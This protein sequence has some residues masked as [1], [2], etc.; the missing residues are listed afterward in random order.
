MKLERWLWMAPVWRANLEATLLAV[1]LIGSLVAMVPY[2]QIVPLF[3]GLVLVG[4][5]IPSLIGLRRRPLARPWAAA[6]LLELLQAG[7]ITLG[8]LLIEMAWLALL[9]PDLPS[10]Q[11]GQITEILVFTVSAGVYLFWRVF[12]PIW[13][14]WT[15]MRQTRFAWALTHAFLVLVS[16]AVLAAVILL[17]LLVEVNDSEVIKAGAPTL[18]ALLARLTQFIY[19]VLL[20]SPFAIA[21]TLIVVLPP[22]AAVS[23]WVSR[24]LARRLERLEAAAARLSQGDWS[25]R[26]APEGQDEIGRLQAS[27]NR[28]ASELEKTN[29]DLVAQRD[30]VAGLLRVQRELTASVSHEL[31]TPVATALAYLENDLD[32]LEALPAETLRQDLEIARHEIT[33]LQTLI[34]DLFTLSKAEVNQLSLELTAVDLLP[35]IVQS[36][37]T[38]A[39]LAWQSRRVQVQAE[40]PPQLPFVQADA[41]RVEQVLRNLLANGIRHTPPGGFVIVS[42][43]ALPAGVRVTVTDSGEGISAD[44]LPHIWERFYRGPGQPGDGRSGLGLAIVKELVESMGGRVGVESSGEGSVFMFDLL[45]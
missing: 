26:V 7:A 27:F 17:M 5:L 20:T 1:L 44:D 16:G 10:L 30:R 23:Y 41:S 3:Q 14:R 15:A 40:L 11:S 45:I 29:H 32:R 9:N 43:E 36:V 21:P 13:V 4:A 24:R 6:I 34:D 33:R 31:R 22:V 28:M 39:G 37:T 18:V 42:A 12:Q 19:Y 35:L 2:L 8:L 25:A 38:T